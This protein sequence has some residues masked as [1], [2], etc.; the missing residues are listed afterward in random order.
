M[1]SWFGLSCSSSGSEAGDPRPLAPPSHRPWPAPNS[2][3][4]IHPLPSSSYPRLSTTTTT[5]SPFLCSP[6]SCKPNLSRLRPPSAPLTRSVRF[7]FSQSHHEHGRDALLIRSS[8]HSFDIRASPRL[9]APQSALPLPLPSLIS[10]SHTNPSGRSHQSLCAH[11]PRCAPAGIAP[12]QR[13]PVAGKTFV[14]H[15]S[16]SRPTH[17][18]KWHSILCFSPLGMS[19]FPPN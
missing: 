10:N 4:T 2:N 19:V 9:A 6:P 18:N 7:D 17:R 3:S 14:Q 13:G 12:S 5:P 8:H 15:C 1:R 11:G 16:L